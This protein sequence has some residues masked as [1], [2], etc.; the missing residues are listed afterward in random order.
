MPSKERETADALVAA[1]NAQ[2][3]KA[4]VALRTPDCLR[5]FLPPS[6]GFKPQTNDGYLANLTKMNSIFTS[7]R[8]TINDVVEGVSTSPSGIVK[9]KIVMYISARGNTPVGE[10]RNEYVWKMGFDE[11]G[12]KI[13]EWSE[14]VDVGM[15]RDFYPKLQVAIARMGTNE[16]D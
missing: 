9:K 7:F 8:V 11:S 4:I 2:D 5:V 10:Y 13:S 3:P 6:L 15:V 1:F 12:E 14:Y 16:K